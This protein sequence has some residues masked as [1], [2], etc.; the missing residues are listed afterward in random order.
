MLA[1]DFSSIPY[2]IIRLAVQT[3]SRCS[4]ES[5][6]TYLILQQLLK[7]VFSNIQGYYFTPIKEIL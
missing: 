1:S 2:H 3:A 4:K 5:H 7:V 6:F